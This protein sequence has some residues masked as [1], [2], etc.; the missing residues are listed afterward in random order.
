MKIVY[1]LAALI[2]AFAMCSGHKSNVDAQNAYRIT[3]IDSTGNYY[4][5]YALRNDSLFKIVSKKTTQSNS[6]SI[7]TGGEYDFKLRSDF[8]ELPLGDGTFSVK[9]S[10]L[11]DCFGY[12]SLTTICYEENCVRDLFHSDNINGLCIVN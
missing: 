1:L 6:K 2:F 5:I 11:V 3:K 7:K 4:L 8:S 10:T 12:D 9:R